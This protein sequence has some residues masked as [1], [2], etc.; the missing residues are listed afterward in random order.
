MRK[1]G[2]T[3]ACAA[4]HFFIDFLCAWALFRFCR[5]TDAWAEVMLYYNFCA[6]ALQMPLGLLADR[7]RQD[8]SFMVLG[9]LLVG[10]ACLGLGRAPLAL[11]VVAGV[12]NALYHVG[13]GVAV[14]HAYARRAGPLGVF[15]SPGAFGIFFG[16]LLGK[17]GTDILAPSLVG[18]AAC[19]TLVWLL[20]GG[21]RPATMDPFRLDA[22]FAALTCLFLVVCL[23][24]LLGF[25]FT[26]P[27][28]TGWWSVA[29]ACAVVFGKAAGGYL[30][31]RAGMKW[32]SL[33]SLGLAALG[34]LFSASPLC[35]VLAIFF[36][37]MTMPLT[38]RAAADALP[39]M[40]GFS[41]GLLTFALF[42]GFLPAWAGAAM[43]NAG[44]FLMLGA[45]V[46]LGL[47]LPG[48]RKKI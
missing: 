8:R 18:L 41:F 17:A 7:F 37:N 28:K 46:S 12:G 21:H 15:V 19:L 2:M 11:A 13:G 33:G 44:W 48:L 27:W 31:D 16:T 29:A 1:S 14:L 10:L 43:P 25:L 30:S 9:S 5:P 23:R 47:L 3:A 35:G 36:F 40:Q 42:L 45:L 22:P 26:F 20:R 38:L 4:G 34:F 24:S 32:A 39:G 6:F